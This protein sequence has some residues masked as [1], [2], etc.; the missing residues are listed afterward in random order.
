MDIEKRK[1]NRSRSIFDLKVTDKDTLDVV[2]YLLD[3]S[4]GGLGIISDDPIETHQVFRLELTVPLDE[5]DREMI[6][7]DATS[8]WCKKAPEAELYHTGFQFMK[9]SDRA[10]EAFQ[11][12]RRDD[13]LMT[14]PGMLC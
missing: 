11:A 14:G 8:I 2:G 1:H 10:I 7:F 13:F 12:L 5:K 6:V 4:S 3:L 9:L